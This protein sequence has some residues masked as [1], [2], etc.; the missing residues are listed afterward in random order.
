MK[1]KNILCLFLLAI[2]LSTLSCNKNPTG[3]DPSQ[4]EY[5]TWQLQRQSQNDG[6]YRDIFFIDKENGWAT[7]DS[8][9]IIHTSNSGISWEYQQSRM[10]ER[11][12]S[13]HFENDK[14]GWAVGGRKILRTEDGGKNWLLLYYDND[15]TQLFQPKIYY[16]II[17]VNEMIGWTVNN[18]GE[19]CKTTDGGINWTEQITWDLGGAACL[20]FISSTYGFALAPRNELYIT[21]NAGYSWN[22]QTIIGLNRN[23]EKIYFENEN[24]GWIVTSTAYNNTMQHGSPIYQS[25]DG[26]DSWQFKDTI[27]DVMLTSIVFIG[28]K[29]WI[30]GSRGIYQSVN[31]GDTW[32]MNSSLADIYFFQK[33]FA[34][35][36]QNI[37]ALDFNGRIFKYIPN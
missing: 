9:N 11:I 3:F 24:V 2:I 34:L 22:K 14:K 35:D 30:T 29:G 10:S 16:Q 18:Y 32:R 23:A 6:Y 37:W 17:F 28:K 15:T 21:K 27:P 8:G 36:E 19:M 12:N 31:G 13:I 33:V 20:S 25:T 5:G 26:G 4:Y 7:G 1:K